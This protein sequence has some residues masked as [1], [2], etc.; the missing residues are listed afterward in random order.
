MATTLE[1]SIK[2]KLLSVQEK[3]DIVNKVEAI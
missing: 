3:L 1:T 2:H